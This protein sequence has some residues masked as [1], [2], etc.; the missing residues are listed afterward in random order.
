MSEPKKSEPTVQ[1]KAVDMNDEMQKVAIEL[2]KQ[3]FQ[4]SAVEKEIA[5]H[6]KKAFDSRFEPNWHCVVGKSFGSYC[7]HES[8]HF[9]YFY[10]D[11]VAI[12]LFKTG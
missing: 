10:L 7:T 4:Q 1:I 6:I 12:L 5:E 8:G 2:A 11:H 3:A 9:I